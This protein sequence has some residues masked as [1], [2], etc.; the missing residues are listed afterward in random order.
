MAQALSSGLNIREAMKIIQIVAS[1][2]K[3]IRGEGVEGRERVPEIMLKIR[4]NL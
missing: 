3:T 2:T 1:V 4:P